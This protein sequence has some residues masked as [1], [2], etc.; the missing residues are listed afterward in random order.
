MVLKHTA[1]CSTL[2]QIRERTIKRLQHNSFVEKQISFQQRVLEQLDIH[3]AGVGSGQ[4]ETS[5]YLTPEVKM[6]H[7]PKT[8]S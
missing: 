1:E 8:N 5:F 6:N 3:V 2:L 7:K 4:G